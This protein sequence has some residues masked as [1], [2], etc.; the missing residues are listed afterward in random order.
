MKIF[1]F[2]FFCSIVIRKYVLLLLKSATIFIGIFTDAR[3]SCSASRRYW[4]TSFL[5]KIS[6]NN[7][8][9]Q[10]CQICRDASEARDPRDAR[11]PLSRCSWAAFPPVAMPWNELFCVRH[12]W[13]KNMQSVNNPQRTFLLVAVVHMFCLKTKFSSNSFHGADYIARMYCGKIIKLI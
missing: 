8:R 10:R 9:C 13:V 12:G 11:D 4:Q 2:P 3:D 1:L 7:W 6:I 5:K